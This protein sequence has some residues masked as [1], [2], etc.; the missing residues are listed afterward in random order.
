MVKPFNLDDKAM[1]TGHQFVLELGHFSIIGRFCQVVAQDIDQQ[2]KQ[3]HT[4][5]RRRIGGRIKRDIKE[6]EE[7][8]KGEKNEKENIKQE[9]KQ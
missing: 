3:D 8:E 9:S 4:G 5:N 2:V 7:G 1:L 6:V